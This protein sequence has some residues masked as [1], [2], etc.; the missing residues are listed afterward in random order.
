[1][2]ARLCTVCVRESAHGA[3]C[4]MQKTG[5]YELWHR[6]PPDMSEAANGECAFAPAPNINNGA[7]GPSASAKGAVPKSAKSSPR[8]RPST[9]TATETDEDG[10]EE[11]LDAEARARRDAILQTLAHQHCC[12]GGATGCLADSPKVGA[13]RGTCACACGACS[14]AR[15]LARYWRDKLPPLPEAGRLR[16]VFFRAAHGGIDA[17]TDEW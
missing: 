1:M 4:A 9:D 14:H 8:E 15:A 11:G 10:P 16:C 3:L 12:K 7:A 17:N 2:S 13:A 5:M 6:P